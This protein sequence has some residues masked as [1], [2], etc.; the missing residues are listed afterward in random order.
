MDSSFFSLSE[1]QSGAQNTFTFDLK[2]KFE[3]TVSIFSRSFSTFCIMYSLGSALKSTITGAGRCSQACP[4]A[5][6]VTESLQHEL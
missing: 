2:P 6:T 1:M 5:V 4:W 3:Q